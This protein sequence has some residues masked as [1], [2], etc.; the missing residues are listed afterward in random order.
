MKTFFWTCVENPFEDL[1]ELEEVI[2]WA[3]ET[4]M[5]EFIVDCDISNEIL[6]KFILYSN[7]FWFYKYN[8]IYFYTR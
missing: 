7:S 5:K 1:K 2:D 3:E 8:D 6:K 4:T